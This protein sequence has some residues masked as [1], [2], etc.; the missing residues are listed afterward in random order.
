MKLDRK[1]PCGE[2]PFRRKAPGG[3]L[4]AWESPEEMSAQ[5][6]TEQGLPCHVSYDKLMEDD[7]GPTETFRQA[8]V[9]VGGL[10][11]ANNS[12][13]L[14]RDPQLRKQAAAVGKSPDVFNEWEFAKHH[15]EGALR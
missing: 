9:C 5:V 8:H 3:W 2:C 12:C 7:L 11:M 1:K 6:N 15:N 10:Q 4:G 13:K 14:Y